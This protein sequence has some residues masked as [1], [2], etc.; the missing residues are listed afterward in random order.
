M[1]IVSFA[2]EDDQKRAVVVEIKIMP[3][4]RKS[5]GLGLGNDSA[6][7]EIVWQ[8]ELMLFWMFVFL[9][10][11]FLVLLVGGIF[12]SKSQLKASQVI[13]TEWLDR[14][15]CNS[16][17]L[18]MGY[19]CNYACVAW[20]TTNL[21][22]VGVSVV[23]DGSWFG[24]QLPDECWSYQNKVTFNDPTE[25]LRM[26][27]II[28]FSILGFWLLLLFLILFVTKLRI[29]ARTKKIHHDKLQLQMQI[30]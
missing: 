6:I 5:T 2:T 23:T 8:K 26:F 22:T 11:W 21:Q 9:F 20:N 13:C 25:Q 30:I 17:C 12:L 18:T 7:R 29:S 4:V 14:E 28:L 27:F 24:V 16:D 1:D 3:N 10:L 19:H 15:Q